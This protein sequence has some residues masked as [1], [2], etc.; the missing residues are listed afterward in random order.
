MHDQRVG[1]RDSFNHRIDFAAATTAASAV[2]SLLLSSLCKSAV[3]IFTPTAR[4]YIIN[5][6]FV[7]VIIFIIV[8]IT[9]IIIIIIIIITGVFV[10]NSV[11][12]LLYPAPLLNITPSS[13]LHITPIIKKVAH[14]NIDYVC[15]VRIVRDRNDARSVMR[16]A[17]DRTACPR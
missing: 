11:F 15:K 14:D 16:G 9:I 10:E 3:N 12:E 2:S 4:F 8:V 5:S 6:I 7:V 13:V 17:E 1:P